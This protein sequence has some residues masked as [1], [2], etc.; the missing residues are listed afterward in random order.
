[1]A[2]NS[3]KKTDFYS[4]Y[5]NNPEI[6]AEVK[7]GQR[8][9]Q[10]HIRYPGQKNE[11]TITEITPDPYYSNAPSDK[12]VFSAFTDSS[13]TPTGFE[14]IMVGDKYYMFVGYDRKL[15]QT[16]GKRNYRYRTKKNKRKSTR[17]G[18]IN[19]Y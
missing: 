8:Y 10:T 11:F 17:K 3:I 13:T 1:M 5:E 12:Q 14:T 7:V 4:I 18:R 15:T 9:I 6:F 16:G 19:K 2:D